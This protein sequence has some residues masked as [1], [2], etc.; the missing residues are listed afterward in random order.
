MLVKIVLF[1]LAVILYSGTAMLMLN[2]MY[3]ND[4][5]DK[6]EIIICYLWPLTLI[7][8]GS[9]YYWIKLIKKAFNKI[10]KK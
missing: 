5:P 4:K 6:I 3:M 7:F 1:I 9:I 10:K 2:E 8:G